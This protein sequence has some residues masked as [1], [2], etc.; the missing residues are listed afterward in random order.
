M[1]RILFVLVSLIAMT[2]PAQ[3][4]TG[5]TK[6]TTDM[7]DYVNS[8]I[9]TTG[10]QHGVVYDGEYIYTS[11]WGKSST[12]L[13]MFYKYDLEGNFIEEFDIPD[14]GF[15]RDMTYDGQ[16]F[17]GCDVTNKVW[18]FDLHAK[19]LISTMNTSFTELRHCTYDP[20]YDGFWVGS[21]ATGSNP[22]L[23]LDLRLIDRN[24]NV[25][26]TAT[27]HNLG[28][29]SVHGTGY[30]TDE[31]GVTHLYV[32]AVA[33]FTAHVFDYD[34]EADELSSSY[35]FDFGS[36]PG[37]S[38]A[39]SA[40]GAYIG[41]CNGS[42][43]FFGDV[44]QSPN[45]IGIYDLGEG[46]PPTPPT[47]PEGDIFFDFNEGILRWTTID[48]DGDGYNWQLY[49]NWA[50]PENPFSVKS[51]SL[52]DYNSIVLTPDN[53][54]VTPYKLDCQLITFRACAQDAAFP[55]EHFGIAVSTEGNTD[56]NDFTTVW[57]ATMTAKEQGQWYNYAVDLRAYAG[58]D[59][60]VA[61]RHFNCTDQF[62]LVVDDVTL[63]REWDDVVE[64]SDKGASVYPNPANDR[65]TVNCEQSVNSYVIFNAVG[66]MVGSQ[67]VG[68]DSFEVDLSGLSEGVYFIRLKSDGFVKTERFVKL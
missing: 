12:V 36:T 10:R 29:H 34:I 20:V 33:G 47:P 39:G 50:N 55:A 65:L 30:F 57:E 11:A 66:A 32:F 40:G 37:F 26:K 7:W 43:Y 15:I 1:K 28:A 18:C 46:T 16:Y 62:M 5:S 23:H 51:A 22:N 19:T 41:D 35:I 24:G 48:A 42:V 68:R 63:V 25:I 27:A 64:D 17:Y 52:D 59:I 44:D 13:S 58:Q 31:N 8:F 49:N 14:C 3:A 53:Y 67:S 54:L 2:F 6:G 4:Q 9:C 38:V 45:L 21:G 60:W 61:F 56:P